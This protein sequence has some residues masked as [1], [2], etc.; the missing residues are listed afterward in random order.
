MRKQNDNVTQEHMREF[1]ENLKQMPKNIYGFSQAMRALYADQAVG[2]KSDAAV[3]FRKFRDDTRQ[4]AM[5]YLKCI[6]PVTNELISFIKDLFTIYEVK[7]R[8]EEWCEFL[9]H[10]LNETK[11]GNNL[12]QTVLGEHEK[13]IAL[14]RQREGE[15]REVM[16]ELADLY[17]RDEE[18]CKEYEDKC[19]EQKAAKKNREWPNALQKDASKK[20]HKINNRAVETVAKTLV[21]A[22]SSFLYNLQAVARFFKVIIKEMESFEECTKRKDD[23][24]KTSHYEVMKNSAEEIQSLCDAFIEVLPAVRTDFKALPDKDT[25]KNYVDKWLEK[26]DYCG[27]ENRAPFNNL[28]S[29]GMEGNVRYKLAEQ[30]ATSDAK[31]EKSQPETP[32]Q[33]EHDIELQVPPENGEQGQF[34]SQTP[35]NEP[36]IKC[37]ECN[38]M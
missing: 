6:L 8:C 27:D 20:Q 15:V 21:P 35:S 18:V 11:S 28:P 13:V 4:D 1:S 3:K 31:Q 7:S 17:S 23:D 38:I 9:P 12:A 33:P 29:I 36:Q 10:I 30:A 14:L 22:M 5:V 26:M 34:E 24:S 25:D 32:P 16:G 19:E 2:G 37:C